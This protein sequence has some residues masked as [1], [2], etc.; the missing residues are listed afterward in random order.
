[1]SPEERQQVAD[2]VGEVV[3]DIVEPLSDDI[4]RLKEKVYE[5]NG[6]PSLLSKVAELQAWAKLVTAIV[7]ALI[8]LVAGLVTALLP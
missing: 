7:F 3:A 1:M 5:G 2:I 4:Q 8:S 6:Q